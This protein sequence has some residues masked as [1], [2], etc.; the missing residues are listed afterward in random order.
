MTSTYVEPQDSQSDSEWN[1]QG[2]TARDLF[3]AVRRRWWAAL[4]VFV[5]VVGWNMWRTLRQERLYQASTTVRIQDA[6]LPATAMTGGGNMVDWRVDRLLSEQQIIKSQNV[7]ESVVDELGLQVGVDPEAKIRR[8]QLFDGAPPRVVGT[9]T[10]TSYLLRLGATTYEVDAGG[11]RYG[12]VAYG[13]SIDAA[14]LLL[15]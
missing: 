6:Q 12:P 5:V 7:A 10:A 8:G 1:A 2:F 9:P 13:D 4:L 15:R 3:E 11:Q 14:G